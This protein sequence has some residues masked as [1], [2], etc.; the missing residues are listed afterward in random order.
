VGKFTVRV[1]V[2]SM[3][4]LPVT[5]FNDSDTGISDYYEGRSFTS[6]QEAQTFARDCI[7]HESVAYADVFDAEAA[8]NHTAIASFVADWYSTDVTHTLLSEDKGN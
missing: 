1:M 3:W 5:L 8:D 7:T 4:P 2:P 6:L